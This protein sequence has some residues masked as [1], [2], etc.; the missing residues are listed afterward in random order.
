MGRYLTVDELNAQIDALATTPGNEGLVTVSNLTPTVGGRTV[1]CIRINRSVP[2]VTPIPVL[3]VGGV[4]AREWAPPDSLV[5]FARR[6]LQAANASAAYVD[7]RF[8]MTNPDA[9]PN[10]GAFTGRIVFDATNPSLFA[11]P[12][13]QRVLDR[14]ELFI[15]PCV[16]MDGRAYSQTPGTIPTTE[17]SPGT[18][19]NRKWWRKNRRSM[20]TC[21]DGT[22]AI[23]V[24]INRNFSAT[25][26]WDVDKYYDA[27]TMADPVSRGNISVSTVAD[28]AAN[29]GTDF[30]NSY[31]GS[32]VPEPEAQNIINLVRDKHIKF[33]LDVHSFHR[34]IYYS[35]GLNENQTADPFKSQFNL[36]WNNEAANPVAAQKGRPLNTGLPTPTYQEYYPTQPY[37]NLLNGHIMIANAMHNLI[38]AAAGSDVH[39]QN[40]SGYAVKPSFTLYSSPGDV[41]DYV[42]STQLERNPTSAAGGF[43]AR[44]KANFPIHSFTIES[45]HHSDGEF[46]PSQLATKNQFL[47]VRREIQFAT[48]GLLKYVAT[49]AAPVPLPVPAPT[50]PPP[51][52]SSSGGCLKLLILLIGTASAITYACYLLFIHLL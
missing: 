37:Y 29:I 18:L 27:A 49:W 47:K 35:W 41:A 40:R 22:D 2:G 12:D 16:N 52:S 32:T 28:S 11:A 24:D 48:I 5:D 46:W 45:G 15:V 25:P 39:A 14:V 36:H 31:H 17:Q 10:D 43:A 23:G 4:H 26:A 8:V 30:F 19:A 20:G 38:L 33:F 6:F 1:K 21:A 9:D 44:I 42:F 51:P 13:V 50:P 34:E 3:I 7:A